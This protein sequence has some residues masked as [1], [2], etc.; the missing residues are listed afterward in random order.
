MFISPDHY[1]KSNS[2][3]SWYHFLSRET[4][5]SIIVKELNDLN[6]LFQDKNILLKMN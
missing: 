4:I 3:S 6:E 5:P 2:F 1:R